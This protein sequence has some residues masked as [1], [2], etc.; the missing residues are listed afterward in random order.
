MAGIAREETSD[1][2]KQLIDLF[3]KC[4]VVEL[5]QS[6]LKESPN[7]KLLEQNKALPQHVDTSLE[8]M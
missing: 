2:Q 8:V 5:V 6:I 4:G 7:Q 1:R 3:L